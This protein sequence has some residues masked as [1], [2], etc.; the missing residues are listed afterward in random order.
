[1]PI[2]H[3]TSA[4]ADWGKRSSIYTLY[5]DDYDGPHFDW[6]PYA[7]VSE[8]E[9]IVEHTRKRYAA[10]LSMCDRNLGRV[11]DFFDQNDLWKDTLLIVNTDHGFML[12]EKD[13][14][15][16]SVMPIVTLLPS[17]LTHS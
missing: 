11:I 1:M 16:K 5:Q 3:V 15:A 10:L 14:W 7:P 12:G 9:E 13:W 6:P 4:V 2:E 17:T 8:G